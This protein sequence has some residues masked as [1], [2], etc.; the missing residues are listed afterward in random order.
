MGDKMDNKIWEENIGIALKFI[1]DNFGKSS[2]LSSSDV[3]SMLNELVPKSSRESKWIKE[4]IDLGIVE[5][6]LEE[7]NID[8]Y[9]RDIAINKVKDILKEDGIA[10]DR[11]NFIIYNLAYGLGWSNIKE[12]HDVEDKDDTKNEKEDFNEKQNNPNINNDKSNNNDNSNEENNQNK[13]E[14]NINNEN[15][16]SKDTN[17]PNNINSENKKEIN[18]KN[19]KYKIITSVIILII[20]V[21]IG[22]GIY[23]NIEDNKVYV[24]E[25]TFDIDYKKENSKYIFKKGDFIVM[26]VSLEGEGSKKIDKNKLRYEV[27]DTSICNISN[28][29]NKCRITVKGVGETKIHI[30]YKRENIESIDLKFRE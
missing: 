12:D 29:F 25:L 13:K 16:D 27:D 6:F 2:L 14:S 23:H 18:I 11:I 1:V 20:L 28:E 15:E 10:E 7:K 22:A 30:Y 19:R 8:D 17:Y 21:C 5:I 24:K 3:N 9:N 26:D 4:A